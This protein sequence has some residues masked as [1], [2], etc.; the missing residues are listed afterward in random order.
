MRDD[1]LLELLE[2]LDPARSEEPPAPGSSRYTAIKERAMTTTTTLVH[3][4]GPDAG[5]TT[6]APQVHQPHRPHRRWRYLAAAAAA[7]VTVGAVVL[8]PGDE[9]SAE[10]TIA[11]AA[12]E[13]AEVT[14]LRADMHFDNVTFGEGDTAIAV[15]G[16]DY[17]TVWEMSTDGGEVESDRFVIVDNVEYHTDSTGQTTTQPV[18]TYIDDD[19]GSF[20]ESSAAVLTAVLDGTDVDEVGRDEV[21][22]AET[23]HYRVQIADAPASALAAL[24]DQQQDWFGLIIGDGGLDRDV[25][26]DIWVADGLV[27]RFDISSPDYGTQ[28]VD[29]H[30]FNADITINP[31]PGPYTELSPT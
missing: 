13:L 27:R 28:S 26:V 30:D 9:R 15:S 6:P 1:E 29:F 11:A 20:A 22:G 14:S 8:R 7:V 5:N 19:G 10:A 4:S 18:D 17:E 25:T 24:P 21:Q 31:P 16:H 23:T 3:Q 12:D 2:Q